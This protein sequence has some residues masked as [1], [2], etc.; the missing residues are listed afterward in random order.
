MKEI[1]EDEILVD[2]AYLLFYRLDEDFENE[3]IDCEYK[4]DNCKQVSKVSI[5]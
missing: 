1:S 3:K 4:C 5:Y 2:S